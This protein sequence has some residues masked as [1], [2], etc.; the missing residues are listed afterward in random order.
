MDTRQLVDFASGEVVSTP[1]GAAP[2]CA[3]FRVHGEI[4]FRWPVQ[5]IGEGETRIGA[6]LNFLG[7]RIGL[8]RPIEP[9][10]RH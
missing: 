1:D 9:A 7:S 4:L 10:S 5:S 2:Y 6:A 3:I 8:Q